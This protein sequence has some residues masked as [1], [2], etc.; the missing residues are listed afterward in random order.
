MVG[1]GKV[2]SMLNL[3]RAARK[4][5]PEPSVT[6]MRELVRVMRGGSISEPGPFLQALR[7]AALA[8]VRPEMFETT[9]DFLTRTGGIEVATIQIASN[10]G[11]KT[12]REMA[13]HVAKDGK[14]LARVRVERALA[15]GLR[16]F[17]G[18]LLRDASWKGRVRRLVSNIIT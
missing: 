2:L 13:K 17:R 5:L 15:G 11:E 1:A 9:R 14:T 8:D 3:L 4:K 12:L 7:V 16:I 10:P 6:D 18:G